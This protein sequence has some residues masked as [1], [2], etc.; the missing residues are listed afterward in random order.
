MIAYQ[1][2]LEALADGVFIAQDYRFVFCNPALPAMLGY[3]HDEFVGLHFNQ[4]VAAAFLQLWT[5]RY[6]QRVGPGEEPEKNY[7]VQFLNSNGKPIW[8]ELRANRSE[9]KNRPAVLGIIRDISQRKQSEAIR[10]QLLLESEIGKA[11][12]SISDNLQSSIGLELH[13]NLG[14]QLSGILF[15]A[16]SLK[17]RIPSEDD[18]SK[19]IALTLVDSLKEAI[20]DC[21]H[22][23]EGLGPTLLRTHGLTEALNSLIGRISSTYAVS[24][25]IEGTLGK[26]IQD[27]FKELQIYRIVQESISNSIKHHGAKSLTLK[28]SYHREY[29]CIQIIINEPG[30]YM[31]NSGL[32]TSH[33]IMRYRASLIGANLKIVNHLGGKTPYLI[34]FSK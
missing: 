1:L 11:L 4:V 8:V 31:T 10:Q 22:L 2:L 33:N 23:S 12:V 29:Y 5:E 32:G 19:K 34:K 16:D 15:M 28:L 27:K 25:N 14:Q 7:E 18:Q 13:E 17:T 21:R 20:A 6:D 9:F 3:N 24:C 26:P 30:S